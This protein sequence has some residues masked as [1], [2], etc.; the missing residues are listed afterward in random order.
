MSLTVLVSRFCTQGP[1]WC[2]VKKHIKKSTSPWF[3]TY[4]SI[5]G[6]SSKTNKLLPR[7]STLPQ[8]E[9]SMKMTLR[10]QIS[11]KASPMCG[12]N[13]VLTT[14]QTPQ[15][16]RGFAMKSEGCYRERRPNAISLYFISHYPKG[17]AQRSWPT[18]AYGIQS[19][20]LT[21][22]RVWEEADSCGPLSILI[23][24]L[25][26]HVGWDETRW[27]C[28]EAGDTFFSFPEQRCVNVFCLQRPI[29][30]HIFCRLQGCTSVT[31]ATSSCTRDTI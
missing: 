25:R 16:I 18:G 15:K 5:F 19:P 17:T 8:T 10:L 1:G 20:C 26:G 14:D 29:K 2:D 28:K 9:S 23:M 11:V 31:P 12:S 6:C 7:A 24:R 30:S 13:N 21:E 4:K 27:G 3:S 22:N